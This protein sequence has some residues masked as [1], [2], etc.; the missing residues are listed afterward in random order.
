MTN[1]QAKAQLCSVR[2]WAKAKI[3]TG[4]E[5]PWSWYQYMKLIETTDAILASMNAVTLLPEDSR[6]CAERQETGLRLVANT[7]P[8]ERL[9]R[10]QET[11]AVQMPT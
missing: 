2:A 4:Q 7:E 3:E 5:P 9:Q 11:V 8:Q 10:R 6:E 1:S